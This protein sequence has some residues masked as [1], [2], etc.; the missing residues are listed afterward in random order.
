MFPVPQH[1]PRTGVEGLSSEAPEKDPV[2]DLLQPLLNNGESSKVTGSQVKGVRESLQQAVKNN[3]GK[4]HELLIDNFPSISSQ[5][6]LST[7]LRFDLT[8]VQSKVSALESEIDHSDPQ[9]SFL[10]P[11]ITS[12]NRHFSASS[13]RAAS[14]AHIHA[15]KSLSR[16]TERIKRLEEAIWLGRGADPWVLEQ[17]D[18]DEG[19]NMSEDDRDGQ[20]ILKGTKIMQAIQ[21]KEA[22][23]KTMVVEQNTEGFSSTISFSPATAKHG[24]TLSVQSEITLQHPR[25]TPPRQLKPSATSHYPLA[26][27]FSALSRQNILTELLQ[28]LAIKIQR[29]IIHP[30]VSSEKRIE[31]S[32]T[33]KLAILRLEP[34]TSSTPDTILED[35][36]TVLTF[37][38]NSILAPST[39]LPERQT[40]VASLTDSAFQSIL[41][42]LILPTLP[43]NLADIPDWL[44]TVRRAVEVESEF[45]SGTGVIKHFFETD[46]G[47]AWAAQRRYTVSDDVRTLV[48]RGWGGWESIEKEQDV[49]IVRYVEVEVEDEYPITADSVVGD[50][51]GK[52]EGGWGF[53]ESTGN[54]NVSPDRSKTNQDHVE[55]SEDADVT[56]EDDGWG[57]DESAE[58]IAGPSS[59]PK[60]P[61]S[62]VN[63][64]PPEEDDGWGLDVSSEPPRPE[65]IAAAPV[66]TPKPTK[67]AREAKRLGKKVAK[68][69]QEDDYDPWASPDP[70][71]DMPKS[72]NGN[73]N[74][75][76][77][78]QL[79]STPISSPPKI[80]KED[81]AD[82]GWGW[83]D[84]PIP[85]S[86]NKASLVNDAPIKQSPRPPIRKEIREERITV[87]ERYLVSTSCEVLVGFAQRLLADI[88]HI[89][90]SEFIS[91]S[92]APS[93]LEPILLEAVKEVFTLYRAFLPT[94]FA[95]QLND[96]P[97][98]AMQARNDALYLSTLVQQLRPQLPGSGSGS[99]PWWLDGEVQRLMDLSEYLFENHLS[100]QRDAI[101]EQLDEMDE[102]QNTADD[103]VY[104]KDERVIKGL[105]H[106]LESLD[107]LIKPILP[108][109]KHI[110]FISYLAK[111]LIERLNSD[112][113]GM[114]DITEIESNRITDLFK[115]V[116]SSLEGMFAAEGSEGGVV[117]YVG[118]GWLKFC[119]ISEILQ[120]SLI[121]ITYLIDSGSLIDFTP[122]ELIGLVKALFANSE[123]RD[124]VIEKIESEG[125][126]G[127]EHL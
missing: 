108:Q 87:Q 18:A 123:K 112:V 98:L 42:S 88:E 40:F 5:I 99:Q 36:Q 80:V 86:S 94:H 27:L 78:P 69:K 127:N 60:P 64:G 65:H 8:A 70:G 90:K 22:L 44:L 100:I 52:E 92:F 68:V 103:K 45:V 23:L 3:K 71:E 29:E 50:T 24:A 59:P 89:S 95:K 66:P 67:P 58:P 91:P 76:L 48:T 2:L 117:R 11:L 124:G 93:S 105:C 74:S 47:P 110:E 126:G 72:I 120:A 17:L 13:S 35:I 9:T 14:Q 7:S 83:E 28:D 122:D 6:Q 1:L 12:L 57:F 107:R 113:L 26:E 111:I 82:D 55:L 25:T 51:N 61:V 62:T 31:L 73:G 19:Y 116:T 16:R 4:T 97:S 104:K 33:E 114:I 79:K 34:T 121:D 106:N 84:D 53:S 109:S 101:I 75:H 21:A 49:E 54:A 32:T 63:N 39:D 77:V 125:L 85:E 38:F 10:P 30:I 20:R 96:V 118:G 102:L 15:L 41:D 46:V 119:Y 115:I 56:M 37:T 43:Q 81:N